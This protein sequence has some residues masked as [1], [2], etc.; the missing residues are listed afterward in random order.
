MK[1]CSISN[2]IYLFIVL[3]LFQSG[4][5]GQ[6]GNER[7]AS[8][9]SALE[10]RDFGKALQLLQ[11]ALETSP[12]NPQLWVFQGLAYSGEGNATAA[13]GS[14]QAALKIAPDYLPA[15]RRSELRRR[16]PPQLMPCWNISS[17]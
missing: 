10:N 8:I 4:I 11:P 6:T 1:S 15:E 3:V 7:V 17:G 14:Y 9:T 5:V 12:R 13:L 16:G 2:P